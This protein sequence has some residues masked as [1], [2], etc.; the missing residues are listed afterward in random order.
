[1]LSFVDMEGEEI[2]NSIQTNLI[3]IHFP[4]VTIKDRVK[5]FIG[6]PTSVHGEFIDNEQ[7]AWRRLRRRK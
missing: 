1:M 5:K 6:L 7:C 4:S 2:I 3:N